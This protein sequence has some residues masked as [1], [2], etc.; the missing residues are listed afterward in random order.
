MNQRWIDE[1]LY[2][3]GKDG[4]KWPRLRYVVTRKHRF[5][6]YFITAFVSITAFSFTASTAY[7]IR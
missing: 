5:G 4:S 6:V 7:Q 2:L 3:E 1:F